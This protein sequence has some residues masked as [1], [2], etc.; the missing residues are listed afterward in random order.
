MTF[1]LRVASVESGHLVT[2]GGVVVTADGVLVRETLWDHD[3]WK[4]AFEPPP[5]LPPAFHLEGRYASLVS[6]WSH[7][8]FHWMFEALP[9]LAVLQASGVE[10]DGVI[11]CAQPSKFHYET[12]DRVGISPAR[13]ATLTGN[14][15][16]VD[17]LVW[18]S[19]LAP[20]GYPTPF[21]VR[22]LREALHAPSASP[23]RRLYLRRTQRAVVNEPAI[24][25]RLRPL[26]F[27]AVDSGKLSLDRQLELFA[28]TSAVVGPHGAA[29]V[30]SV[31]SK[32]MTGIEFYQPAHIN[33]SI[34]G[35]F[36]A[37]GHS[38]W[39]ITGKRAR[40][41]ARPRHQNVIVPLNDLD[42]TLAEALGDL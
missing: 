4:R 11:I 33:V 39:H 23:D 1:P 34:T 12:L 29:F 7:N 35:A 30:N 32:Q 21:L 9:R 5:R 17:E 37:A 31:F 38:H 41:L 42:R 24:L 40:S 8:Y 10:Y 3:H 19:P 20:I 36:A 13:V 16:V 28:G 18:S 14:H 2:S 22:W 25:D 6:L 27:E 26:G 15:V